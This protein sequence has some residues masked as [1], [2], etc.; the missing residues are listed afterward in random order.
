LIQILFEKLENP[1]RF[2]RVLE[3]TTTSIHALNGGFRVNAKLRRKAQARKRKMLRR[4]DKNNWSG[5]SP[6]IRPQSVKYELADK[7]H[8][9]AAGG[10][11]TL[12]Q[13]SKQLGLRRS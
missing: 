9:I 13:L 10:I 1:R 2:T 6:M 5:T 11:G 8:A 12:L 4:I 7:Q 3:V